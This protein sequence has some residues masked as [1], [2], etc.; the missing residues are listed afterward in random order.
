MSQFEQVAL[1]LA[2]DM[3]EVQT[4]FAAT[5]VRML[6]EAYS[7]EATLAREQAMADRRDL[8][9]WSAEVEQYADQLYYALE[10]IEAGYPVYFTAVPSSPLTVRVAEQAVILNHPRADQQLAFERAVLAE[11]CS[12]RDCEYYR[13]ALPGRGD[14][15][16]G[17]AA[18]IPVQDGSGPAVRET[19]RPIPL[20]SGRVQPKWAFTRQGQD[21]SQDGLQVRFP[22]AMDLGGARLTCEQFLREAIALADELRTQ[23]WQGVSLE[24]EA[25]ELRA[26]P[27]QPEH[28]LRLNRSGDT[29]YAILPVIN[30]SPGLLADLRPW[31][32]GQVAGE[33]VALALEAAAYGWVPR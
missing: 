28:Q 32:R 9:G 30:S 2:E 4:D 10:E 8:L 15:G 16:G 21:C 25:L 29:V 1:A 3:P 23:Q 6:A 14:Y 19:P 17:A 18:D 11:F 22:A 27:G 20:S 5:A 26:L 7:R 33:R 31:L 24:W 12:R 13:P